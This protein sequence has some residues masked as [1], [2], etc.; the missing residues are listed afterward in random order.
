MSF[1]SMSDTK[2]EK[3][4]ILETFNSHFREF[5]EDVYRIFPKDTTISMISKSLGVLMMVSKK[6]VI[7]VF[8]T[9]IVDCYLKEI[10]AGDL[11]FFIDK[12]YKD[13]VSNG[14]YSVDVVLEKIEYIKKLV[15]EM[16][17]E[18]QEN[19][20]KYFQNLTILCNMFYE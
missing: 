19:V 5:V 17:K 6:Q 13:D 16:T 14:G 9:S 20:I 7:Q 11:S 12:N 2:D 3:K 18:E 1:E 8:K 4:K 15:K 10:E